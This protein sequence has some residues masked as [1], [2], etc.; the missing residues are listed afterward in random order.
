MTYKYYLNGKP[1]EQLTPEQKRK[2]TNNLIAAIPGATVVNKDDKSGLSRQRK[3]GPHE[4]GQAG[5]D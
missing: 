2:L 1:I 5:I 3:E 4:N